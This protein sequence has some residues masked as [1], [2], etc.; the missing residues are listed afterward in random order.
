MSRKPRW[1][2][3]GLIISLSVTVLLTGCDL[4]STYGYTVEFAKELLPWIYTGFGL[5]VLSLILMTGAFINGV[6]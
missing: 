6:K 3:F 2:I 1:I 4:V 5:L